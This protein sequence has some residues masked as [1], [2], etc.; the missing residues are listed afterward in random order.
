MCSIGLCRECFVTAVRGPAV[1]GGNNAEMICSDRS[2]PRDVRTD[3]LVRI[4][5]LALGGTCVSVT[6]SRTVLEI[7]SRG[8]SVGID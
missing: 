8:Q 4:P 3:I 7:N 1:I 5:G 2:Q 6:G